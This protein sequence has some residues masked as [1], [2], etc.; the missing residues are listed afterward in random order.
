V[1]L[2]GTAAELA[3]TKCKGQINCKDV[4]IRFVGFPYLVENISGSMD[5]TESSMAVNS[6]KARH[7]QVDIVLDGYSKGFRE[8]WDCNLC[9]SSPNMLLDDDLYRALPTNYKKLWLIFSPTGQVSGDFR[10]RAIGTDIRETNL[11][12]QLIN[13]SV[14]CQYFPYP[15]KNFSGTVRATQDTFELTNLSS[16][17][18]GSRI[19]LNGLITETDTKSPVYDFTIQAENVPINSDLIM[20]CPA[21]Q[22]DLIEKFQIV[23]STAQ[24]NIHVFSV[25]DQNKPIDYLAEISASAKSVTHKDWPIELSN[26][27]VKAAFSSG[28]L[29]I[30]D[31]E[32]EYNG[33]KVNLT[34]TVWP[35]SDHKPT[36]FCLSLKAD[37]I[38]LNSDIINLAID[39]KYADLFNQF[40]F[41]GNVNLT[42]DIG[43]NARCDCAGMKLTVDCLGNTAVFKNFALP[44]KDITGK[45]IITPDGV[46]LRNLTTV[47]AKDV[48]LASDSPRLRFDA[49]IAISTG[50][51]QQARFSVLGTN[52]PLDERLSVAL[53][54]QFEPVYK[55]IAPTGRFDINLPDI[56]LST[57]ADNNRILEVI[58]TASLNNCTF[59]AN[60][61]ISDFNANLD[62][63]LTHQFGKG[64][65]QARILICADSLKIKNRPIR[66]LTLPLLFQNDGRIIADDFSA[67]CLGGKITGS[68]TLTPTQ[69]DGQW[70]Y[71]IHTIATG[72]DSAVFVWPNLT[73]NNQNFGRIDAD[74]AVSGKLHDIAQA[75]GRLNVEVR[76]MKPRQKGYVAQIRSALNEVV[77]RR[78]DFTTMKMDSYIH[79]SNLDIN[80]LDLYGPSDAL[81]GSGRIDL[82]NGTVKINFTVHTAGRRYEPS[83]IDSLAAGLVP[84]FLKVEVLGNLDN[85]K[86]KTTPLPIIKN[87]L[88]IIGTKK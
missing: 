60:R 77:K 62:L 61:A 35:A 28:S 5:V 7:G 47:I 85:P 79:G 50:S 4:S 45:V 57:T 49:D 86:I 22:R 64:L 52:L 87:S 51:I 40:E 82:K 14:I 70:A 81:R 27:Y 75:R 58:G 17:H 21:E 63:D 34:G 3:A 9:L 53:G 84:A 13:A 74:L 66:N 54:P 19:T 16:Q 69:P 11:Q 83:F 33:S 10:F 59:F 80:Q 73:D 36:G 8:T 2:T 25:P 43:S 55:K 29:S 48:K 72:I 18:N 65:N 6:L 42:A 20:A 30:K 1:T 38:S 32:A 68:A 23:D 76:N 46:A 71:K 24:G 15:M 44:L 78:F 37:N 56:T 31:F 39:T 26:V 67:D 88:Q 41:G 12:A